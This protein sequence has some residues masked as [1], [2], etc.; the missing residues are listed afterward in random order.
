MP[1]SPETLNV[2]D[3]AFWA[4][5]VAVIEHANRIK[6]NNLIVF[7]KNIFKIMCN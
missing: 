6:E 4:Y 1:H 3:F 7:I 5:E 2:S